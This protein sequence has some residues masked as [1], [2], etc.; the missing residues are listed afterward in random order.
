MALTSPGV[1]VTIT[2]ESQYLPAA[3]NSVPLVLLATASNKTNASG[4]GIA[5]ATTAANA[6][7][8]YQVTSQRD[9]VNLYGKPF[10]YETT[11]GTPIQ[12]YEL[13]EYGLLAAYSLL[14]VTNR[15]Y[16][17]RADIDLASL[18]GRTSRPTGAPNN[19]TWWFDSLTSTWGIYEFNATTGDFEL[20]TPIVI[21]DTA[22][23]SGGVPLNSIG[24]IGDY[25]INALERTGAPDP[26]SNKTFFYK[27]STNTWV[28]VGGTTWRADIPT[29]Q[30]TIANPTLSGTSNFQINLNGTGNIT[31][32]VTGATVASVASAINALNTASVTARVV[33]GK[34]QILSNQL[35]PLSSPPPYIT[36]TD[37]TN[38]P[39]GSCGISNGTY[40]QP[41]MVYGTA[42][43]MPLWSA[44]Q[45]YPRPSGSVWIKIG[46]AGNG[47]VPVI[48]QYRAATASWVVKSVTQA[49]T[50]AAAI[51]TLDSTGGGAIPAGTVYGQYAFNGQLGSAPYYLWV[52]SATGA[53][54][55]I[56][57]NTAPLF[58][59]ANLGSSGPYSLGVEVSVP[60]SD[61]MSGTY[62]VTIPNNATAT[63]FVT[64]WSAAG[65]PNTVASVDTSG[66]LVLTHTRGGVINLNDIV[67]Q[68]SNGVIAEAGFVA[69]TTTGCKYG[70]AHP[71]G[72]NNIGCTGGSGTGATFNIKATFGRYYLAPSPIFTGG[73][74]YTVGD[75]LT[76][77]GTNLSGT[78]PTNNLTLVVTK[79][80]ADRKSVV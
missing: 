55:V 78:S 1:E 25:A 18:V 42:S 27:T 76:V 40:Y 16:V 60:G 3:T 7:K 44:S 28:A 34:L 2:D 35:P 23:L 29:V 70:P 33:S 43:Q 68:V 57:D 38:T 12:G 63:D 9:L 79:V 31:V 56:G 71:F 13:N 69:G 49:L 32:N 46:T 10:F 53:T 52:R 50:D 20:Q 19:G 5:P 14:G 62:G 59:A 24:N 6:N 45:T 61:T 66:A 30:G 80:G 77:A 21:T 48:S 8:L 4:T 54:T 64:A 37:G 47:L 26:N 36:L 22:S 74:G 11:N 73:T 41:A 75:L 67:N 58:N 39:L 17:L 65:I 72:W 51:N 15:C